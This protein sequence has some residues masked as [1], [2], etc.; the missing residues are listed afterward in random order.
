MIRRRILL[1]DDEV[2]MT[3]S[4][5]VY[6]QQNGNCDVRVENVGSHAL[7]TARQFRPD[8]I[9]LDVVLPD[10]DGGTLA[11]DIK[12]D[13]VL[14]GTPIVFLTAPASQREGTR[15]STQIGGYPSLAKPVEPEFVLACIEKYARGK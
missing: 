11:A 6:L 5:A 3:R 14:H 15:G 4:L 8:L 7:I 1:V 12:S 9:F 2:S 10:A 13:P